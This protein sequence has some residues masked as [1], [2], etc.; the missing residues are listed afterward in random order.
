MVLGRARSSRAHGKQWQHGFEEALI[1]EKLSV[2]EVHRGQCK[3]TIEGAL[4][5]L[6]GVIDA[7]MDLDPRQVTVDF[8]Q[9]RIDRVNLSESHWIRGLGA[10]LLVASGLQLLTYSDPE[11]AFGGCE[12]DVPSHAMSE[13]AR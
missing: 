5:P 7:S 8:D 3:A 10:R 1:R 6:E 12:R 9:D 2:P 13:T 4:R 11:G